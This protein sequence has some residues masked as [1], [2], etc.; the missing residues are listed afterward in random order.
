M[1]CTPPKSTAGSNLI[2]PPF[3]FASLFLTPLLSLPSFPSL[4]QVKI[5]FASER[6]PGAPRGGG[7][8]GPRDGGGRDY[9]PRDAPRDAP[10]GYGGERSLCRFFLLLAR[11]WPFLSLWHL[12]QSFLLA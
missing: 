10:R 9:P 3:I 4:R 12:L 11:C 7:Y 6:Q 5:D 1:P 8:A 2:L